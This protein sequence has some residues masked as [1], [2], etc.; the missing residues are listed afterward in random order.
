M[1]SVESIIGTLDELALDDK[2]FIAAVNPGPV[3]TGGRSVLAIS[4]DQLVDRGETEVERTHR[5]AVAL[6]RKLRW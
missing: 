1:A 5:E 4:V 2:E 6:A 3:P